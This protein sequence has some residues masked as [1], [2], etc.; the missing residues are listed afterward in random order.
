MP[1]DHP[2]KR[3]VERKTNPETKLPLD[4]A[5]QYTIVQIVLILLVSFMMLALGVNQAAIFFYLFIIGFFGLFIVTESGWVQSLLFAEDA[6]KPVWGWVNVTITSLFMC[7][8]VAFSSPSI[9]PVATKG[10]L[11]SVDNGFFALSRLILSI[12]V[13]SGT[14]YALKS[15]S[16]N[17]Y[18]IFVAALL[19]LFGAFPISFI[20]SLPYGECAS[21]ASSCY[22]ALI[23]FTFGLTFMLSILGIIARPVKRSKKRK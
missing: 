1:N 5:R 9:F 2:L 14:M 19:V 13:S 3:V 17:I 8:A 6:P 16:K 10:C 11:A 20:L 7:G 15:L 12:I 23:Y 4:Y 21:L 18:L 22:F